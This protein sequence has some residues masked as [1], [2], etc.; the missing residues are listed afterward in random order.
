MSNNTSMGSGDRNKKSSVLIKN[1]Q[2]R[3]RECQEFVRKLLLSERIESRILLNALK[4]YFSYWNDYSHPGLF[5]IVYEAV[6]CKTSSMLEPQAAMAMIAAGFD[7]HDDIVDTSRVKHG[8]STVYG[9]FGEGPTLLL[10]DAFLVGG[11]TL[12]GVAASRLSTGRRTEISRIIKSCLFEVGNAHVLELSLKGKNDISQEK[13]LTILKMKSASFEA[14]AHVAAI[15]GTENQAS[16]H[17]MK[18]YGRNIGTLATL[19][20]EFV[21]VFDVDELNRRVKSEVLP[22]PIVC[23]LQDARHRHQLTTLLRKRKL[24]ATDAETIISIVFESES[25]TALKKYMQGLA[26]QNVHLTQKIKNVG[27]KAL[28]RDLTN[29]LLEDL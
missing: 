2:E 13:Y 23:A 29:S 14:D 8:Y 20:D 3:S 7:L 15:F 28:L 9:K 19:R 4:H 11:F 26:T 21:D 22:M 12:L 25:V 27:L 16:T 1:L 6:G 24:T 10:G 5:S 18:Q 17:T